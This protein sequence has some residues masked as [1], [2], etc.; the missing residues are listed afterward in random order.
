M[1]DALE[2]ELVGLFHKMN[3]TQKGQILRIARSLHTRV[4]VDIFHG[5]GLITVEFQEEFTSR[6]QTHHGTHSKQLDRTSFEDA[7]RAGAKASG[8]RIQGAL[9]ATNRY[10]D[11][12]ID[13][14]KWAL[15]TSA[16]KDVHKSYLH[17]SK[18]SEAVWIQDVR[19]ATARM[20]KTKEYFEDYLNVVD[21]LLQLRVHR[22]PKRW[23]YELVEVPMTLFS[24]ILELDKSEFDADGPAIQ[25]ED[26]GGPCLTLK[27]DRSDS[28]ITITRI[29]LERCTVHGRW[30]LPKTMD[31]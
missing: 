23:F 19:S 16:A 8:R 4:E 17:I 13:G 6:L 31:V 25:V 30:E 1:P 22:D 10:Y 11:E 12:I 21:R 15:K 9:S 2:A 14:E 29:P 18:L 24:P 7:F 28:K 5:A 26:E 3:S 27:L 20:Q